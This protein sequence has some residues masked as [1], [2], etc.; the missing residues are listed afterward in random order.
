MVSTSSRYIVC[1]VDIL[2]PLGFQK[3]LQ[4]YRVCR[5]MAKR[6][7]TLCSVLFFLFSFPWSV[8][9][10]LLCVRR[11]KCLAKVSSGTALREMAG[12][13]QHNNRC[14]EK[15]VLGSDWHW[16][17]SL[18]GEQHGR[19]SGP[20]E[21]GPGL[22]TNNKKVVLP[23]ARRASLP[24][25]HLRKCLMMINDASVEETCGIVSYYYFN[26]SY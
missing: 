12:T 14:P 23:S 10:I 11:V 1:T 13:E 9:G 8:F 4:Q 16:R 21:V 3:K 15:P 19:G 26:L 7:F 18:E 20:C 17:A 5:Q 25:N 6:I 24:S 2:L 22:Y